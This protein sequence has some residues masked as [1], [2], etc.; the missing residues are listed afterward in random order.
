[1]ANNESI[2]SGRSRDIDAVT[3]A[4]RVAMRNV[5]V[6]PA[7][8]TT[9]ESTIAGR[10]WGRSTPSRTSLAT[11]LRTLLHLDPPPLPWTRHAR[12]T[13]TAAVTATPATSGME[14][15]TGDG[16]V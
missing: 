11:P 2:A 13:A 3:P 8:T 16:R 14:D 12:T 15:R 6:W 1:M 9:D 5:P 4:V 10:A 7:T